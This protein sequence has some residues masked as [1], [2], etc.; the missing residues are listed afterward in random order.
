MVWTA[1][2]LMRVQW[3]SLPVCGMAARS[4]PLQAAP[5]GKSQGSRSRAS[6]GSCGVWS[7]GEMSADWT[8]PSQA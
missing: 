4:G 2:L 3:G 8:L 1:G 6:A 5:V 7:Y